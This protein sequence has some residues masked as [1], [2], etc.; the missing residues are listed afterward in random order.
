MAALL[1]S[2]DGHH[3][4]LRNGRHGGPLRGWGEGD[5]DAPE[6][7]LGSLCKE[8]GVELMCTVSLSLPV[9]EL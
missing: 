4:Y 5:T 6:P 1:H 8:A 2:T 9:V 7:G 3:V